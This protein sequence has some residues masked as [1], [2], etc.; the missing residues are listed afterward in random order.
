MSAMSLLVPIAMGAHPL[1]QWTWLIISVALSVDAHAGYDLPF[2]QL[3]ALLLP[4][5]TAWVKGGLASSVHHDLHHQWPRT[6][7]EP[8]FTYADW[9]C[10]TSFEQSSFNKANR[11]KKAAGGE[12]LLAAK[13]ATEQASSLLPG[14]TT[15][16]PPGGSEGGE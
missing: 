6:N 12:G 8:F 5:S 13:G 11:S 10:G 16:M 1:T 3:I 4:F 15:T 14:P 7:F 2:H 9:L